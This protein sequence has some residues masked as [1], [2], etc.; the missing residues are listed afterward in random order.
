M[1]IW[2]PNN[3]EWVITRFATAKAGMVLVNI[4]P[5][6]PLGELEYALNKVGCTALIT[7]MAL[8]TSNYI[9]VL[10]T[11]MPEIVRHVRSIALQ[12][13]GIVVPHALL[14]QMLDAIAT[15]RPLPP[16]QC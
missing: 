14:P 6:H 13:A 10:A 9:E 8:K 7:A 5:A 4:N 15:L 16:V 11:L 12:M 3:A 1:V 2:S